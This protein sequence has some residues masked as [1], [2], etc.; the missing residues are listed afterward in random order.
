M[1]TIQVV[2]IID[3]APSRVHEILLDM[4]K[5]PDWNP[6]ITSITGTRKPWTA[7]VGGPITVWAKT[8]LATAPLP[9]TVTSATPLSPPPT[10]ELYDLTWEGTLLY[11]LAIRGVHSFISEA[12]KE[13]GKVKTKFT[14]RETFT[15]V[16]TIPFYA[17]GS[18]VPSSA[19]PVEAL[20]QSLMRL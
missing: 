16:A 7:E 20:Y 1:P 6:M 14:H 15:G 5:Y 3:A 19:A 9:C 12:I 13:D 11:G 10:P 17:V 18:V 4:A 2:T 8:P